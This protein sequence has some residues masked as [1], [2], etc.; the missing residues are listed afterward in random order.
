MTSQSPEPNVPPATGMLHP[1]PQCHRPHQPTRM[2]RL[3]PSWRCGV[4][5]AGGQVLQLAD[6]RHVQTRSRRPHPHPTGNLFHIRH[7]GN[8][9]LGRRP[10]ICRPNH[11]QAWSVHHRISA[12][13]NPHSNCRAEIAVKSTKRLIVRTER[14][15]DGQL[16]PGLASISQWPEPGHRHVT[17]SMHLRESHQG[18]PPRHPPPIP[19]TPR[20][21]RP[22]G[23]P[24][25]SLVKAPSHWPCQMGRTFPTPISTSLRRRGYDTKSNRPPPD[26]VG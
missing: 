14:N 16:P 19:P 17:C 7:P 20:L 5:C 3:F 2:R 26:E 23:P 24:G 11:L 9:D 18:P 8:T 22:P 25:T 13:Y 6:S 10:G 12:A 4:S 21:V 1:K 15:T